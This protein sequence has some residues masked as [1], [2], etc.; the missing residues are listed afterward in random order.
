ME[1]QDE[2]SSDVTGV[3][4]HLSMRTELFN[5]T[6]ILLHLQ[7]AKCMLSDKQREIYCFRLIMQCINY[8]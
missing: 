5:Y 7:P 2:H 6:K 1:T 3:A 8:A 4:V